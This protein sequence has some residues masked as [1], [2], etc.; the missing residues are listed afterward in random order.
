V[1]RKHTQLY[2]T[3]KTFLSALAAYPSNFKS[4]RKLIDA[5]QNLLQMDYR[6]VTPSKTGNT[7]CAQAITQ[8]L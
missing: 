5:L 2:K 1:G 4:M 6:A 7:G 3:K 8:L